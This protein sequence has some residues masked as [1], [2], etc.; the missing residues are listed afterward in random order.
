MWL[1]CFHYGVPV[2]PN[3]RFHGNLI[4]FTAAWDSEDSLTSLRVGSRFGI[5]T[6]QPI[7]KRHLNSL[8]RGGQADI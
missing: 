8:E 2:G 4:R 7:A 5:Y 6:N 1:H 3:L